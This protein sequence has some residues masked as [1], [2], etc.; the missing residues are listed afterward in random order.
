MHFN[1]LAINLS[2]PLCVAACLQ[3]DV[4]KFALFHE[5]IQVWRSMSVRILECAC[6]SSCFVSHLL[7]VHARVLSVCEHV[8][9][10]IKVV[11]F[12]PSPIQRSLFFCK[13]NVC[14]EARGEKRVSVIC[15]MNRDEDLESV[16]SKSMS[17]LFILSYHLLATTQES[18]T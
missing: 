12:Q 3:I 2:G 18:A 13:N 7:C 9:W 8:P 11:L 17:S 5:N 14:I 16:C 15:I 4:Y 1:V 10:R 6:T